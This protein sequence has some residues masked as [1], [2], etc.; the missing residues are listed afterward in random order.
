MTVV[1]PKY[2]RQQQERRSDFPV[3][4]PVLISCFATWVLLGMGQM[5]A[6]TQPTTITWRISS[7]WLCLSRITGRDRRS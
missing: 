7:N 4:Q 1:Q 6:V 3:H 5:I 2:P